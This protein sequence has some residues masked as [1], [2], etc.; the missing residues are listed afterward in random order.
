MTTTRRVDFTWKISTHLTKDKPNPAMAPYRDAIV[1][2]R[3][4]AAKKPSQ[5]N[6]NATGNDNNLIGLVHT[7]WNLKTVNTSKYV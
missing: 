1:L 6:T 7:K 2:V 3:Q 4:Q 5:L